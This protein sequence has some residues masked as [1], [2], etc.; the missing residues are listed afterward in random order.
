MMRRGKVINKPDKLFTKRDKAL[1]KSRLSLLI[2]LFVKIKNI[3]KRLCFFYEKLARFAEVYVTSC[4][5]S[6]DSIAS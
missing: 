3:P 1:T 4:R 2:Y 6:D 5:Q